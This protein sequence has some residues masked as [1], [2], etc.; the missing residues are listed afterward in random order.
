[1]RPTRAKIEADAKTIMEDISA[2]V[3]VDSLDTTVTEVSTCF[4]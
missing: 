2:D 3:A 1:V 4:L